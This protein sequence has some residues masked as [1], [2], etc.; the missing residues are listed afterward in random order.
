MDSEVAKQ[1][2]HLKY[3][4]EKDNGIPVLFQ[5]S[6]VSTYASCGG[7]LMPNYYMPE[8]LP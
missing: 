6:F 3:V 8:P 2:V 1:K 5:G 4:R 7:F